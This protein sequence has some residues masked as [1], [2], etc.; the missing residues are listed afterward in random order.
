MGILEYAATSF[1]THE[2]RWRRPFTVMLPWIWATSLRFVHNLRDTVGMEASIGLIK[3]R[4]L[5]EGLGVVEQGARV[6]VAI[7]K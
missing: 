5:G 3:E 6:V 2:G 4:A 7:S 1:E